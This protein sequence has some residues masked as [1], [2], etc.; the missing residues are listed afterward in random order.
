[1]LFKSIRK[2]RPV[3]RTPRFSRAST[4]RREVSTETSNESF[5][6]FL[7][8]FNSTFHE[9]KKLKKALTADW[10]KQSQPEFDRIRQE[11]LDGAYDPRSS[12]SRPS[13][14]FENKSSSTELENDLTDQAIE[15][16]IRGINELWNGNGSFTEPQNRRAGQKMKKLR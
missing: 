12:S 8:G 11:N 10:I 15:K 1:M 3:N 9:Q 4:K 5:V 13:G 14:E 16:I 2:S 6:R 7:H